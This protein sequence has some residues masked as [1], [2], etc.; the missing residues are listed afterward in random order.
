LTQAS[1][2]RT[3]LRELTV[4]HRDHNHGNNPP[5]GSNWELL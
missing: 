5:N 4:H 2:T 1:N 3:N